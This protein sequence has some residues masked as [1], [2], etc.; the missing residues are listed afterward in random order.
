MTP[1]TT[2]ISAFQTLVGVLAGFLCD[3]D[4]AVQP[5]RENDLGRQQL[6]MFFAELDVIF[7]QE[8]HQS[9]QAIQPGL[10]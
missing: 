9:F 4:E 10:A 6:L 3:C 7:D 2:V 1:S 5:V 8:G